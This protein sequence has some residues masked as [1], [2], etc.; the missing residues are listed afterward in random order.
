MKTKVVGVTTIWGTTPAADCVARKAIGAKHTC[1]PT[2]RQ[3]NSPARMRRGSPTTVAIFEAMSALP[4]TYYRKGLGL[5]AEVQDDIAADYTG[6]VVDILRE[7]DFTLT[8]GDVTVRLAREFGFC[9]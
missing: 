7:R 4:E 5:K 3:A 6:W 9:Y 2:P 1:R 8:V